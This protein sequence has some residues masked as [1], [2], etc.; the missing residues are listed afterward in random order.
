MTEYKAIIT[1]YGGHS[2]TVEIKNTS[3]LEKYKPY[4]WA[5]VVK[6]DYL[7]APKVFEFSP[8]GWTDEKYSARAQVRYKSNW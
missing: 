2:E 5:T 6:Y 7:S 3:E 8:E 4:R 1:Y